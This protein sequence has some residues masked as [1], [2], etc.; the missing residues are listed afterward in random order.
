MPGRQAQIER[1]FG[2]ACSP[3][4]FPGIRPPQYPIGRR[5]MCT[6]AGMAERSGLFHSGP[7]PRER[8]R[9]GS[10]KWED[11]ETA[12]E[13]PNVRGE[14]LSRF[15]I[16]LLVRKTVQRAISH[17]PSLR[18]MRVS[19]HVIRHGTAMALFQ[20]GVDIAVIALWLGHDGTETNAYVHASLAMKERRSKK[21]CRSIR[22]SVDSTPPTACWRSWS[23]SEPLKSLRFVF[24]NNR[25]NF[26]NVAPSTCAEGY[27]SQSVP[28]RLGTAISRHAGGG[29][30]G[31]DCPWDSRG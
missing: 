5:A 26:V 15:A 22:R 8:S 30:V 24:P 20:A 1:C 9:R 27:P 17:C 6:C 11:N 3:M 19:P 13:F 4:R 10:G 18:R 28:K 2:R 31:F 23:R 21:S 7:G 29:D 14:P 16:H 25:P 12:L